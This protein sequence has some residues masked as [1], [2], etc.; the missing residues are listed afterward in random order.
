MRKALLLIILLTGTY[1]SVWGQYF[2]QNKPAY[3]KF[4][5][6]VYHT[7]HFEIYHYLKND[8]VRDRLAQLCEAWYG[9][10][11]ALFRDTFETQNPIIF[12]NDQG[13]FQQ[14][15]AIS[16]LIDVGTGGVTEG[17]KNRIVLPIASTYAQTNHVLGHEMVHAFQY[18]M[19]MGDSGNY[20]ALQG[21]PLWMIEGMAEYFSIGSTDSHTA[22]WM[23]DAI[24]N[25]NFPTLEMMTTNYSYFPYRFGQCFWAMVG[26][27]WGDSVVVPLLKETSMSG[28]PFAVKKVLGYDENNFSDL[29]RSSLVSHYQKYYDIALNK[30]IG[31]KILFSKNAGDMNISPE[32]SPDGKYVIF[33]SEKEIFTFDLYLAEAQTGK[34]IRKLS[35]IIHNNEIDAFNYIESAGSWSPDGN[36]FVFTIFSGGKNKL[37]FVDIKKGEIRRE[38]EIPGV[39]AF[40]NPSWSPDG[41]QI[42]IS[43]TSEGITNLYLFDIKSKQVTQLTNDSYSYLQ[44]SW[45]GDGKYITF[46][47]DKPI[48]KNAPIDTR[49][50]MSLGIMNMDDKTIKIIDI[51]K[52]AKN[53]NPKFSSDNKSVYFLSNRDGFRNLYRYELT[54]GKVFQYTQLFTGITGITEYSPAMSTAKNTDQISYSYLYGGKYSIYFAD[55]KSF[56]PFEV[57][58]DSLNFEASVLP[59]IERNTNFLVDK[60][61]DSLKNKSLASPDAF[62]TS[63]YRPKFKLDY[64]SQVNIG[65]AASRFSTGMAGSILALFSDMVGQNQLYSVLALNGEIYDFGGLVSY[66]NSK[67]KINWGASVSHIPY[68][69]AY[70]GYIAHDTVYSSNNDTI[71]TKNYPY[72]IYR[73]FEDKISLFAIKPLSRTQRFEFGLSQCWYYRRWDVINQRYDRNTDDYLSDYSGKERKATVPG[74]NVQIL[75]FAYVTDNSFFGMTAPMKGLR[76]RFGVEKYFGAFNFFTALADFRYYWYEKPFTLAMRLMHYGRYGHG[77]DDSRL[78][79]LYLG[80]PWYMRGY[81]YETFTS[82]VGIP[83]TLGVT[84]NDLSGSKMALCNLEVRLPF[85]G[86]KKISMIESGFFLTDWVLFSDIG[87]A[88]DQST[89]PRLATSKKKDSDR[90]PLISLGTS[91]RFNLFGYIVIEP[92]YAFPMSYGGFRNG[93]FGIN[94]QPGW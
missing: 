52:G 16:G 43:G 69:Y 13:D 24:I 91:L 78:N 90:I 73:I 81:E 4:E 33:L 80:Y 11:Q 77:S 38:I 5:F 67:N 53:L 58:P 68:T 36:E 49:G 66:V 31:K 41:R 76:S 93:I 25:N 79:Q 17:L 26:R 65:V 40:S 89:S 2:G 29:W 61:L 63:P 32:L 23:R 64:I 37:L 30:P 88:W 59:P 56:K 55:N 86:P 57:N 22:L 50:N 70:Q 7:P 15:T 39:P 71:D 47:T 62:M 44:P 21:I 72:N 18:H 83:D 14:T 48:D 9:M 10:H 87:V 28:Y 6:K 94:F 54:S 19:L 51:F 12:Y 27:T 35:S 20:Q 75:D 3:K 46:S 92:Y 74:Y 60:Q 42:I 82:D 8:S 34:I 84:V 85:T 45:S 1:F